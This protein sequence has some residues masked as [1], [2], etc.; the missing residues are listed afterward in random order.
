[1]LAMD[2]HFPGDA[3]SVG[4]RVASNWGWRARIE[5]IDHETLGA[6]F[7]I[8]GQRLLTCAHVLNGLLDVRVSFPGGPSGLT[9]VAERVTAWSAPGDAGDVAVLRLTAD[10]GVLPAQIASPDG[11]YWEGDLRAYGFRRGFHQSGSY[12]T[13]RTSDDMV[14]AQEWWQLDVVLD[15]Q[16]RLA[17]GFSGAAVYRVDTGEVV[18]MVTDVDLGGGGRLGRML[19]L[20]ALRRHWQD[21]DDLLPL[22]WLKAEARRQ[23]RQIVRNASAPLRQ[24]FGMAFPGVPVPREFLSAWEA[25]CYVAEELFGEPDGLRRFLGLLGEELPD[26]AA[27]RLAEWTRLYLPR[28]ARAVTITGGQGPA[29]IIVRIERRTRKDT[30]EITISSL[31]DGLPGRALPPVETSEAEVRAVVERSLP[32]LVPEVI[33]RD[34]IIEFAMPESWLSRPVEEWKADGVPILTYPVVV[35]DIERL[36]PAFRQ[37]KATHRWVVLRQRA[38][39]QAELVS[40]RDPRAKDKDQ[41]LYWLTLRDDVCVLIYAQRPRRS[42]LAAALDAGIPVMVWS[43]STCAAESHGE[44]E[45]HMLAGELSSRLHQAH[46]DNLPKLVRTLRMEA[47]VTPERPHCGRRITLLWDDPGRLPDPPLAMAI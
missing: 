17:E 15:R 36:K 26:S 33:G 37:D 46:P 11:L 27:G 10:P 45:A 2:A 1:M 19:P 35:R 23:L 22:P 25:I 42:Q 21:L 34:W 5:T 29:S 13:F 38:S 47:K 41:F 39:S 28:A 16:E 32:A 20:S 4:G 8:D 7:L 18:G 40:C 44:C 12:A 43:R 6:G 3:G 24:L 31:V 14:L 9:A 30:F